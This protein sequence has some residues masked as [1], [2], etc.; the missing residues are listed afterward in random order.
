VV[1]RLVVEVI[2]DARR[3]GVAEVSLNFAGLRR[4]FELTGA[5]RVLAA[6]ASHAF[7]CWI[8]LG[9]L[10]RFCAK[11]QP[12]WRSRYLL[13]RSWLDVGLVAAA[14]LQA[15]FAS[16]TRPVPDSPPRALAA[17]GEEQVSGSAA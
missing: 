7:D 13:L 4:L 2:D 6:P 15:E 9:P 3:R 1:E 5:T 8:R 17:D 16:R 14:A 12:I 11:F 10:Y